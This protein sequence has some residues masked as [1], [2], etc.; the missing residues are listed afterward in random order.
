MYGDTKPQNSLIGKDGIYQLDLEQAV[1]RGDRACGPR[2]SSIIL[3]RAPRRLEGMKLVAESLP[4]GLSSE[5]GPLVIAK[6][7]NKRYLTPFL[8]FIK[9]EM[10]KAIRKPLKKYST[11]NASSGE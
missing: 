10:R 1:E 7:R 6:A 2:S 4:I 8:I 9:P 3:P 5:N 11:S